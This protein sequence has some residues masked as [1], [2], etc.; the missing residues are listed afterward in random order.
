MK[1]SVCV[2]TGSRAEYGIL[3]PLL[4]KLEREPFIDLQLVVT[5]S[6]LSDLFGRT[7]TEILADG[8]VVA[9]RICIPTQVESKLDMIQATAEAMSNFGQYFSEN[10]P[11]LLVVL[12]DRY[13][14]FAVAFAAAVLGI[15]IA[16]LHGGESTEGAIDE[17][18]RHSITKMST[19]HFTACDKYR[20]RVIQLGEAPE[21]VFAYGALSTENTLNVPLMTFE[22]LKKSIGYPLHPKQYGVVTFHPVT[23]EESDA[24]VEQVK[25]L[26]QALEQFPDY[27]FVIT[28]SNADSGGLEVNRVW[29]EQAGL[30]ENWL[31]VSSLGMRRY[32]SA[33]HYA[34]AMIG[35]SSSGIIEG[36]AMKIPT[37]NIGDRQKGRMM[38]R[39]II[40]CKAEK[41]E[42][43][44]AMK[45]AFSPRIQQEAAKVVN[46]FGGSQISDKMVEE[47]KK[48]LNTNEKSTKKVFY[49]LKIH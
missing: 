21:R 31:V 16:H 26:I 29:E 2:V 25:V 41:E 40:S 35:N 39:S 44:A 43:I 15:P 10:R 12:G 14:I 17:F 27:Q 33:L 3:R 45:R 18:L 6:H 28:K 9:A 36:P 1:H 30:H 19:L 48:F 13:E 22:E 38:A 20:Q 7:E 8:F 34:A 46:P 11:D 37:V 47:I 42:I 32:L 5:G 23:L 49:D 4:L 24:P